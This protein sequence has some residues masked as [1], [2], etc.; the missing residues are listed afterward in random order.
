[1][2]HIDARLGQSLGLSMLCDWGPFEPHTSPFVISIISKTFS[3]QRSQNVQPG[4]MI[5]TK[6]ADR[7]HRRMVKDGG[8]RGARG[9]LLSFTCMVAIVLAVGIAVS[10][11]AYNHVRTNL[12]LR[13]ASGK[14]GTGCQRHDD[15]RLV[16]LLGQKLPPPA[17]PTRPQPLLCPRAPTSSCN[18]RLALHF[19]F[20]FCTCL[21]ALG[22]GA[23][24]A[25]HAASTATLPFFAHGR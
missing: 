20:H 6:A 7:G 12:R 1:M 11:I 10:V 16:Q 8:T 5:N 2:E 25:S 13:L 3:F 23:R 18:L 21:V 15:A 24:L 14:T 19:A 17:H 9:L 4:K 22:S